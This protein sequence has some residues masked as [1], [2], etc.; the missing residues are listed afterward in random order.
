VENDE[1][2]KDAVVTLAEAC[3][4]II[5][6]ISEGTEATAWEVQLC[7][8]KHP[9]KTEFICSDEFLKS[10]RFERFIR[11]GD[12]DSVNDSKSGEQCLP[13]R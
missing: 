5:V 2:W 4:R 3:S 6:D 12:E 11:A 1:V 10:H 7:C 9:G 13:L 8:D